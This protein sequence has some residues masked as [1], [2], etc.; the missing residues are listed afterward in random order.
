MQRAFIVTVVTT[1]LITGCGVTS[2]SP[3]KS[4]SF[5]SGP[6]HPHHEITGLVTT[7]SHSVTRQPIAVD[8]ISASLVYALANTAL[9]TVSLTSQSGGSQWRIT[10]KIEGSHPTTLQFINQQDGFAIGAHSIWSSHNGGQTWQLVNRSGLTHVH[11]ATDHLG[12]ALQANQ[13]AVVETRDGGHTWRHC[14]VPQ[15]VTFTDLSVA[16]P[17]VIYAIGGTSSGP[18]LYRSSNAGVT[19]TLLFKGVHTATLAAPYQAYIK[20]MGFTN[21]RSPWPQFKNGGTVDFTSSRNGWVSIFSGSYLADAQLHTTNGGGS[22]HYGWGNNGCAMGCHSMGGGLYPATFL[23]KQDAW[24]Y[25]GT[26][27]DTSTNAGATWSH[28]Q[29]LPF[30]LPPSQT[31]S[32][33]DMF[34]QKVG[35]LTAPAGIYKTTDGGL[36]WTRQWPTAPTSAGSIAM[37]ASQS[38][39]MVSQTLPHTLWMT[40]NGG[41]TWTS[42]AHTFHAISALNLWSHGN[43]VAISL[44]GPSALTEDGG[45]RWTTLA[46]H[47]SFASGMTQVFHAQFLSP[48]RGWVVNASDQL[49][50]T[51][52]GGHSWHPV[53]QFAPGPVTIDFLSSQDGWALSGVKSPG[54]A[55]RQWH[56]SILMTTDG[57]THWTSVGTVPLLE[58]P[59][60][61]SFTSMHIGWIAT[62]YGLLAT[63]NGGHTWSQVTLPHIHPSSVDAVNAKTVYLTTLAGRLLKSQNQGTTWTVLIP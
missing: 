46:W 51:A 61:L 59:S 15:G 28:S 43:G 41:R 5:N 18:A 36:H 55:P 48:Q 22:W 14:L 10:G 2:Q 17:T 1:V 33:M 7:G 25:D 37:R 9:G 19:W 4:P 20:A 27:I 57:G 21:N 45:K 3:G 34:S 29:A 63:T 23:G 60:S 11:F 12:F 62:E 53:H 42:T 39:W 44:P 56:E 40:K 8:P 6:V 30:A 35:W 16:N 50:S 52:N 38:G 32:D 24:R 47:P 54:V 26:H 58:N 31:V 49:L 13:T